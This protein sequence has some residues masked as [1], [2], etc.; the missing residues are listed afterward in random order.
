MMLGQGSALEGPARLGV[1]VPGDVQKPLLVP[2][3]NSRD[4]ANTLGPR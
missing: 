4:P 1:E 3:E 2:E